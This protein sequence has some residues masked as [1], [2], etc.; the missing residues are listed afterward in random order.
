MKGGSRE[1][2]G[3]PAKGACAGRP[4]EEARAGNVDSRTP[5]CVPWDLSGARPAPLGSNDPSG[6]GNGIGPDWA[7]SEQGAERVGGRWAPGSARPMASPRPYPGKQARHF[8]YSSFGFSG[9][10]G[11]RK[12][13]GVR[14]GGGEERKGTAWVRRRCFCL[15]QPPGS[16][17]CIATTATP[18]PASS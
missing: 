9:G 1:G 5:R 10:G 2:Q 13:P 12:G 16:F 8:P 17:C 6:S 15:G 11:H 14:A 18:T 7:V 4:P 3:E